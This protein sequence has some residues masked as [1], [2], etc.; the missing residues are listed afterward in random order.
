MRIPF[1]AFV[2]APVAIELARFPFVPSAR[3]E[4]ACDPFARRLAGAVIP[5]A[6]VAVFHAPAFLPRW[7]SYDRRSRIVVIT[8]GI[9]QAWIEALIDAL[10]A[11]VAEV[12]AERQL[13]TQRRALP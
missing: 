7:P 3:R 9:P 6:S 2:R 12:S 5:S 13:T 1:H 8:R 4:G 10:D 11:E